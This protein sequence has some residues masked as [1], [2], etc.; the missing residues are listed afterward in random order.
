[1]RSILLSILFAVVSTFFT[2]PAQAQF[3][4]GNDLLER[5]QSRHTERNML[6]L[7]YTA[8][9]FDTGYN[10]L[11]CDVSPEVR[12]GQLADIA[13]RYLEKNPGTRHYPARTLV[14]HAFSEAFPSCEKSS[15]N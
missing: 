6:A 14:F 9:V 4:S 11:W 12:V 10:V 5:L 1:M 7:G 3:Y 13:R 8:G 2:S 15:D